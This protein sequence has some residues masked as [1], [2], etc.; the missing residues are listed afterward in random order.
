MEDE[1]EPVLNKHD[2]Q[3]NT[4][5]RQQSQFI[6]AQQINDSEEEDIDLNDE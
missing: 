6:N 3:Q 4:A 2:L 1:L 5:N